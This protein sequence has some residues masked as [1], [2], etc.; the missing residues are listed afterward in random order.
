MKASLAELEPRID[1]G[2]Y[3]PLVWKP[4]EK[5]LKGIHTIYY[6]PVGE[7]YNVPFHS[8]LV[9][10]EKEGQRY[11]MDKYTLHQLTSTRYLA[12]GLKDKQKERIPLQFP[13]WV[14]LIMT[15]YQGVQI[16]FE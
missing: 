16:T 4:I 11:L 7:L 5:H 12:M 9:P 15:I 3:Y 10:R 13:L 1:F 8:F 2:E 6:A 14:E